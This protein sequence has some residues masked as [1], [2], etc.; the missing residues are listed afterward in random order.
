MR[1]DESWAEWLQTRLAE[2]APQG[3]EPEVGDR[4]AAVCLI[5]RIGERSRSAS[6]PGDDPSILFVTRAV[7]DRDP[8]SGHTA[9]PGGHIDDRDADL[10]DT[11]RRE[12]REE[13]GI[14]LP[15]ASFLGRLD[16][17]RPMTRSPS[18]VVSPFVARV[19]G[20]PRIT[21]NHEVERHVWVPER[22][23]RDPSL[24]SEVVLEA[25]TGTRRYP[26]IAYGDLTIWGLTHRVVTNFLAVAGGDI[27]AGA[28]PEP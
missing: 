18:V 25:P 14:E 17:I 13:V 8:W 1:P 28:R 4:R 9:F 11:A 22:A 26:A 21:R 15:R 12:T 24:R 3:I 5:L 27:L 2:W 7:V 23:L 19:D 10:L 20:D 16:D 6:G